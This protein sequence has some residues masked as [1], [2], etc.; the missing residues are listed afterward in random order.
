MNQIE[1]DDIFRQM[2]EIWPTFSGTDV[3]RSMCWSWFEKFTVEEV[4]EVLVNKDISSEE[5]F[6]KKLI[7]RRLS[8]VANRRLRARQTAEGQPYLWL[9]CFIVC[10]R[11]EGKNI[12][13]YPGRLITV[14]VWKERSNDSVLEE[15]RAYC[16]SMLDEA[17]GPA[18]YEYFIGPD[19]FPA[20]SRRAES[21]RQ[22]AKA[23]GRLPERLCRSYNAFLTTTV[24]DTVE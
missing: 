3:Q 13:M 21:L 12:W 19:N 16:R 18:C 4:S 8:E 24:G 23:A 11:Y 6:P 9:D 14:C 15:L 17:Y 10:S 2:K 22:E 20:A 5:F 7:V 1:F